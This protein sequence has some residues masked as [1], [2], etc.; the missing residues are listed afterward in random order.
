MEQKSPL[1]EFVETLR[2]HHDSYPAQAQA[3]AGFVNTDAATKLETNLEDTL[4]LPGTTELV[5]E[6]GQVRGRLASGTW[7]EFESPLFGLCTGQVAG[8]VSEDDLVVDHHS[9]LKE[10]TP[11][12][13]AWV[14]RVLPKAPDAQA[15]E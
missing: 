15:R 13:T 9:V 10:L 1:D 7:V 11:I 6:K 12:K 4:K 8:T 14:V 3:L 2:Q 5:G